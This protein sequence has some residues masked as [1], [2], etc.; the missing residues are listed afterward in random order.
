MIFAS[1]K[2][3]GFKS[4]R[5]DLCAYNFNTMKL[6]SCDEASK[7]FMIQGFMDNKKHGSFVL[8]LPCLFGA[9]GGS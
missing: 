4:L 9:N 6:I 8:R 2:T 7:N 1:E 3:R 5:F